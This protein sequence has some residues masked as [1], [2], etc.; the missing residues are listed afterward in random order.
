MTCDAARAGQANSECYGAYYDKPKWWFRFRYDTQIKRKTVLHLVKQSGK[1]LK[2]QKVLDIGFG[3]GAVL[4]SFDPSC[5]IHGVEISESAINRAKDFA[6]RKGYRRFTFHFPTK[7]LPMEDETIDIVIASHVLEHVPDDIALLR[8]IHR[9]LKPDGIAVILVPINE[10]YNDPNHVRAYSTASLRELAVALGF[11]VHTV[12]EN[13]LLFHIVETFYFKGYN[14][15]WK[16]LGPAIVALFNFPLSVL[17]F[18]AYRA[19]DAIMRA[20]GFKPRQTCLVLVK[21]SPYLR[22]G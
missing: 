19:I 2:G 12:L 17:P 15:R 3:S 1:P 10:R 14:R 8:E 13:E 9:V 16:I 22:K 11:N 20:A 18:F 5:E 21:D 7:V 4:F 6:A